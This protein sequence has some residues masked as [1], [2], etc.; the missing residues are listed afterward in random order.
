MRD[1]QCNVCHNVIDPVAGAFQN[2]DTAGTYLVPEGWFGDMIPPGFG[3]ELI[4]LEYRP[5]SLQWLA[6]ELTN[7]PRLTWQ[8]F[9]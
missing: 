9:G 1:P 3:Y 5:N 6:Q 7:D 8:W 2:W 4:P